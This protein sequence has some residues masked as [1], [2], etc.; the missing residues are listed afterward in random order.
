ME[1]LQVALVLVHV[2]IR[3]YRFLGGIVG[4]DVVEE[5]DLP[6]L[7]GLFAAH[8]RGDDRLQSM[9][10][11]GGDGLRDFVR[12]RHALGGEDDEHPV[13]P[14]VLK[15][16]LQRPRV[17]RHVRVTQ[18]VD[19]RAPLPERRKEGPEPLLVLRRQ[20]RRAFHPSRAARLLPS[21]R[22]RPR[23]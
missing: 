17:S 8:P 2:E 11:H 1:Y 19:V 20:G 15:A 7:L 18:K 10:C 5:E 3:P 23:W 22:C 14:L 16:D 9:V 13:D 4:G 21:P 12:P 6:A